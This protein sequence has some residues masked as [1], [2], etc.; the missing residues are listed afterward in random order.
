MERFE[1]GGFVGR[2]LSGAGVVK[3]SASEIGPR[4]LL[5]SSP[6]WYEFLRSWSLCSK[7]SR[8]ASRELIFDEAGRVVNRA[9]NFSSRRRNCSSSEP[10][11]SGCIARN[12]I[13]NAV[14]L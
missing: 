2:G 5:V 9:V 7:D 1:A 4:S 3:M 6:L 12:V 11:W 10:C 13:R 8:A 14:A